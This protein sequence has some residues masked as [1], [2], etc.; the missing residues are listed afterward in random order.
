MIGKTLKPLYKIVAV[1]TLFCFLFSGIPVFAEEET[2]ER[3][4]RV[5]YLYNGHAKEWVE[6]YRGGAKKFNRLY[7]ED[8]DC[9]LE[10][11]G[12]K[13]RKMMKWIDSKEV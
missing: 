8:R 10:Q 1:F 7:E 4:K 6:E 3:V 11:V 12:R 2:K 13:L 9:R 5:R